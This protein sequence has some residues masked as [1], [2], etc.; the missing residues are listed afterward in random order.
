MAGEEPR[1]V[2]HER[3]R[4]REIVRTLTKQW[5]KGPCVRERRRAREVKENRHLEKNLLL[6]S[7]SG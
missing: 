5:I 6:A 1:R 4:T 3:A 2:R 7:L